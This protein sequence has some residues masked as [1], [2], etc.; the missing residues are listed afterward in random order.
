[1]KL[2]WKF[3]FILLVF[4]LIPLLCITVISQRGT[5]RLGRTISADLS[6]NLTNLTSE[7]LLQAAEN[8]AK[9]VLQTMYTVESSLTVLAYETERVLMEDPPAAPKIYFAADFDNQDSSPPDLAPYRR[10]L[11][12]SD[13]GK[14]VP[15]YASLDHPVFL[16]SRG[17]S[18]ENVR[19]DIN[20]LT[21]VVPALKRLAG[22]LGK[23]VLWAY[24]STESGIHLSYPGHGGYPKNYDP[25][26]RPWYKAAANDVRWTFP[27]VDAATASVIFTASKQIQ[28]SDGSPVG[29]VALDI[30]IIELLQ[31]KELAYDW[32]SQMSSFLVETTEKP[33]SNLPGLLILAQKDYQ[34]KQVSW[35]GIIEKE[36]LISRDGS[37]LNKIIVDLNDVDSGY[38]ELPYKGVASIWAYAS[39]T[40]NVHFVVVVPKSVVMDLPDK[41]SRTVLEYFREQLVYTTLAA[42]IVIIL[43]TAAALHGSR[44]ITRSLL[45][46]VSAAKRLSRGDFSVRLDLRTGDER[47]QV[48][49]AFNELGPKLEDQVHIQNALQLAREVQ[50]SLLPLE[51]PQ[52]SGLDIAGISIYCDETGGDYYDYY[53]EKNELGAKKISMVVGDL[54]GHGLASALLMA[55][56]RALLRQRTAMP[57]SIADIVTDVNRELASDIAE[58]GNFM[59]LLYLM[60]DIQNRKMQWVRAGH[61]PAI[62][63]DPATDTIDE[64][65]GRGIALGVDEFWVYQENEKRDLA[66]GQI[67]FIGT[68]G[69]WETRNAQKQ[70]F[71]K[72]PIFDII[73]RK[74]EASAAEI[75]KAVISALNQFRGDAASED[76]V[77]MMVIKIE[78]TS[79]SKNS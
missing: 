57:G 68:D 77:T 13:Q 75:M 64:L 1:M 45:Q 43:L 35:A 10:Y 70:M 79:F 66:E 12:K 29:V 78:R 50:Q 60:I 6:Q 27:I 67:I 36:W 24:V 26:K 19:G 56:A 51:D 17:V 32:T 33:D 58:S 73:R 63:Y 62:F 69:I 61:D 52:I 23:T 48:I 21:L 15:T 39:I 8:S 30:R 25:R 65:Q 3:F 55:T 28:S 72:E 16:L 9:A 4:S 2:R 44:T 42:V 76:D 53:P 31:E 71:G 5:R 34:N 59:T 49:Q 14:A 18:E 38:V 54:S 40:E 41:A 46:I 11:K 22:K 20:R 74:S 37:Q 47:D 7:A